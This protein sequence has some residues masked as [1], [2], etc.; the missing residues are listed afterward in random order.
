M[1]KAEI[2]KKA[3]QAAGVSQEQ[4]NSVFKALVAIIQEEVKAGSSI[5]IP[6]LGTF[7]VKE[8]PA[9]KGRDPRTAK[10]ITIAAK[11]VPSFRASAELKR[12]ANNEE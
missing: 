1:T 8:K 5:V 2:I 10:V 4:A 12:I 6:A 3:A 11:K 7:G 9:R